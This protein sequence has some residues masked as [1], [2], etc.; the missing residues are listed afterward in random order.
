MAGGAEGGLFLARKHPPRIARGWGLELLSFSSHLDFS[1]PP[2]N[3][4]CAMAHLTPKPKIF[5]RVKFSERVMQLEIQEPQTRNKKR[6]WKRTEPQNKTFNTNR[7]KTEM[8][9][10]VRTRPSEMPYMASEIVS[11]IGPYPSKVALSDMVSNQ[12]HPEIRS[13]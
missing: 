6:N 12:Q 8:L 9:Q 10:C 5:R 2:E 7:E 11:E 1:G 3:S 4:P 13:R